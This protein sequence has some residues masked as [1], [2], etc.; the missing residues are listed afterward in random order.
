MSASAKTL[1][2]GS[3]E[4]IIAAD[5]YRDSLTIQLQNTNATFLA[6][7]EDAANNTGIKLI[8]AGDSVRVLGAKARAAV[9]GYSAG[10]ALLGIETKEGI[11]YRPGPDTAQ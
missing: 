7:G 6:F 11:E 9:N 10:A 5:E 8:N 2:G 3:S 1:T 4:L